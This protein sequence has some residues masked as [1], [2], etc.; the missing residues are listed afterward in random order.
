MNNKNSD[1]G[2]GL[3]TTIWGSSTR[4]HLHCVSFG[5]SDTPT[6]EEKMRYKQ[7]FESLAYVLPCCNCRDSY[8]R[9]ITKTESETELTDAILENR[10]T[11][12]YWLHNLHHKVN[13]K[14][15]VV[16]D[17][18]YEDLCKKYNSYVAKCAMTPEQTMIAYQNAYNKEAH[19]IDY[20]D[21]LCFSEY[22]E[23]RG[24]SDF[25]ERLNE[26]LKNYKNDVYWIKRNEKCHEIIKDMRIHGI[27]AIEQD[28]EFKGFPTVKELELISLMCSN[29]KQ[30]T[31]KDVLKKG[32]WKCEE[33]REL[34]GWKK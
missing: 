17:I 12:T 16:Y 15:G 30:D 24:L 29:M 18:T 13:K 27:K 31:I 25:V 19:V 34:R 33:L 7:Y 14:L 1:I 22:A 3:L 32:E 2:Y 11:L 4:D 26:T 8:K 10:K 9:F 20:I 28:G 6:P 5:Y 23:K 21:A